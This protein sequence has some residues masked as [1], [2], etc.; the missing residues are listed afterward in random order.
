VDEE[1]ERALLKEYPLHVVI[2]VKAALAA[3]EEGRAR[4]VNGRLVCPDGP[5]IP[6]KSKSQ[7]GLDSAETD[8]ETLWF[9]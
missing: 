3:V 6:R 4:I 5:K 2:L 8:S 1:T 9:R 7:P